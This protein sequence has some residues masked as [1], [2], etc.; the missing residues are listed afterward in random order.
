MDSL[1]FV[2]FAI[3]DINGL[4]RGQVVPRRS[5]GDKMKE[6]LDLAYGEKVFAIEES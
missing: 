4:P 1:D 6:G 2:H 3:P 5:V